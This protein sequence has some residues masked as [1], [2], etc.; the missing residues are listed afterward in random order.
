M[1]PKET[2]PQAAE[3]QS[4]VNGLSEKQLDKEEEFIASGDWVEEVA[5]LAEEEKKDVGKA[6][7]EKIDREQREILK[8]LQDVAATT[9]FNEAKMEGTVLT[10]EDLKAL[11]EFVLQKKNIPSIDDNKNTSEN[12]FIEGDILLHGSNIDS[13][14]DG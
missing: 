13:V 6:E 4:E 3:V 7:D 8:D 1:G 5:D 11:G 14:R 12:H 9:T 2:I 10:E